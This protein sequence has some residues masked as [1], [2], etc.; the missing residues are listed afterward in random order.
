M[1]GLRQNRFKGCIFANLTLLLLVLSACSNLQSRLP[2]PPHPQQSHPPR[3]EE[4]VRSLLDGSPRPG[5]SPL[6]LLKSSQVQKELSLSEQQIQQIEQMQV[7][8]RD[9]SRQPTDPKLQQ[10]NPAER[11]KKLTELNRQHQE[12][13]QVNRKEI[14]KILQP[15]QLKRFKEITL[16]IYGWGFLTRDQFANEL[17]LT[18]QQQQQLDALHGQMLKQISESW[19]TSGSDTPDSREAHRQ[20][21]EQ[22]TR[23]TNQQARAILTPD[24]QT[25]L[26]TLKGQKF[27]LDPS[28]LPSG[29][30]PREKPPGPPPQS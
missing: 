30:P 8:L 28:Q 6:D 9:S 20:K 29:P 24:Q 21:L 12:Q 23:Q 22:I 11:E 7:Q 4:V 5:A 27:E 10:L 25:T 17:Q 18:A 14:E 19:P 16:Q 3:E 15:A 13:V 1:N 2:E 26:E